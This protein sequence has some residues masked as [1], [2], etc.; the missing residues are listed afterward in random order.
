MPGVASPTPSTDDRKDGC[1][2]ELG[3]AEG[4]NHDGRIIEASIIGLTAEEA[5][6]MLDLKRHIALA[7][8]AQVGAA[9]AGKSGSRPIG[10]TANEAQELADLRARAAN[11]EM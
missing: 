5:Q 8:I 10:L 3:A 9:L 1:L 4:G 6:A 2:Q 11:D 7:D